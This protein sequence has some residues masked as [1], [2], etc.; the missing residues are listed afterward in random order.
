ML[1]IFVAVSV[2]LCG[3]RRCKSSDLLKINLNGLILNTF[4]H[5]Q[6]CRGLSDDFSITTFIARRRN[7]PYHMNYI[8]FQLY[9]VH[10][11]TTH[12]VC[13]LY[14]NDIALLIIQCNKRASNLYNGL[15]NLVESRRLGGAPAKC[16]RIVRI[17]IHCV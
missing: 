12:V 10:K 3:R 4:P 1:L 14:D 2:F 15:A 17:R 13:R 6:N 8:L 5:M 7:S 11:T 16:M 9:M